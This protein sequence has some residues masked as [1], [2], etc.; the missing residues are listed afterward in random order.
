MTDDLSERIKRGMHWLYCE[1]APLPEVVRNAGFVF[2]ERQRA[3][4]DRH[5]AFLSGLQDWQHAWMVEKEL[6][7]PDGDDLYG[8]HVAK[9]LNAGMVL[10]CCLCG[11]WVRRRYVD[12]TKP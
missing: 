10:R 7:P 6:S 3:E 2:S 8:G 11:G 4:H 12:W 9:S 1:N 5:R